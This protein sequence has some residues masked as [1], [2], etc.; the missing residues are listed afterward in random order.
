MGSFPIA[1]T[2][3][4]LNL[5]IN[6]NNNNIKSNYFMLSYWAERHPNQSSKVTIPVYFQ[7]GLDLDKSIRLDMISHPFAIT[8]IIS[9]RECEAIVLPY[10]HKEVIALPYHR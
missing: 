2:G 3:E 4:V 8:E 7:S 5:N 10:S 6:I 1:P 9:L